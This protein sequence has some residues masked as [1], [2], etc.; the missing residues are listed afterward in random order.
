MNKI[1]MFCQSALTFEEGC[2]LYLEDC[3]KRNLIEGTI[4]HYKSSY[5]NFQIL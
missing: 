5:V 1:K 2:N 4:E 3:R